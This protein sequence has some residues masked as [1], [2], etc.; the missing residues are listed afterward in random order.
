V[1]VSHAAGW[2]QIAM[3]NWADRYRP[4]TVPNFDQVGS[5]PYNFIVFVRQ[6][7]VFAVPAFLFCSG[8]FVAYAARGGRA[9]Y[10]WKMARTRIVDL[11]IPYLLWSLLWLVLDAF[12]HKVF[13]PLEYVA[14]LV[15]G[16]ADGGSY[17]FVPLLCQFYL[18]SPI[19]V[20]IA[21]ARPRQLL[22]AAVFIQAATFG[23]QYLKVFS[24]P[25]AELPLVSWVGLINYQ[26]AFFSWTIYFTLGLVFGFYGERIRQRLVKWKWHLVCL[27]IVAATA[28]MFEAESIYWTTGHDDRYVPFTISSILYSIAIVLVYIVFDEIRIPASAIVQQIGSKS[29]GVYLVHLPMIEYT[30]RVIRQLAP[31][32]LAYQV[33]VFAP[34]MLAVGLGGP[35]LLMTLTRKSPARRWYRYVFG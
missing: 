1:V 28:S 3:I 11:L 5:L 34:L 30:A 9:T 16:K 19:L 27:M 25:V 23:L 21:R 2:G 18:M 22:L 10:S 15:L 29:Y 8:F 32:L 4:V 31:W 7:L 33:T 13:T 17:F 20:P 12:Q 14:L 24:E 26:A 6:L 35:L